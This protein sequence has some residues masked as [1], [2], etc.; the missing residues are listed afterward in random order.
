MSRARTPPLLLAAAVLFGGALFVGLN[1]FSLLASAGQSSLTF[2]GNLI[3]N[4]HHISVDRL[5]PTCP[6]C[7]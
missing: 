1:G 6:Q 3:G 7:F 4:V 5:D 2:V